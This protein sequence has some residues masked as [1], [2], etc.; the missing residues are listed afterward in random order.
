VLLPGA[1][2]ENAS[3]QSL[4]DLAERSVVHA[5]KTGIGFAKIGISFRLAINVSLSALMKLPL[6]RLVREYR[7]EGENWP[8]LI[9]DVTEDQLASDLAAV[10]EFSGDLKA[11]GIHLAIDDF[12][13]G[14]LPLTHMSEIPFAELKL[15]RSFVTDCATDKKHASICKTVIDLAHNYEA[16][17]VAVGVEKPA[18]A[19]S[20]FRMGCDFGQGYL[21][22][23]P[24]AQD[25]FLTLLKQRVEMARGRQVA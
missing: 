13:R 7:P 19:H 4:V 9:L 18:D 1:F 11:C 8:G 12:G 22:A 20:L 10:R 2:M 17:A 15:D 25:R 23:Q 6:Q 14:Y 21:F 24:M 3:A 16:A 5:L